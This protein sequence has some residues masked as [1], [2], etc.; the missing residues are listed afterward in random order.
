MKY[1]KYIILFI[2][3][4]PLTVFADDSITISNL[5]LINKEG[6]AV[7]LNPA[8]VT[9]TTI[10]LDTK[11]YEV[12]DSIEYQFTIENNT[13][14]EYGIDTSNINSEYIN[15]Q[16]K[17]D[18]GNII[19]P[20]STNTYT[21]T[22]T[23]QNE[24]PQNSFK[25]GKFEVGLDQLLELKDPSLINPLTG[26]FFY[27]LLLFIVSICVVFILKL[28]Y[29]KTI[30]ILLFISV[31]IIPYYTHATEMIH[32]DFGLKIGNI[33]PTF[34]TY[35]GEI[36]YG[37]EYVNGQFTYYYGK[38][39]M[40][41]NSNQGWRWRDIGDGWNV[42]LTDKESIDP[43]TTTLCTYIN[44][45]PIT[46]LASMFEDSKT[47]SIDTSS[48][49]T[50]HITSMNSMFEVDYYG[51]SALSELDVSNF[52]TSNV[53]DISWMFSC[54]K[55][56]TSID[57]SNFD[58][59][60]VIYLTGMFDCCESLTSIDVS[61]F[62]TSKVID[63]YCMFDCCESLTSIDV[64][65][66]DTSNVVN[67]DYMFSYCHSLKI[68]D[69]SNFD[70]SNVTT[71]YEMFESCYDL[72]TLNI[73]N[74]SFDSLSSYGRLYDMFYD[75][76]SLTTLYIN[77]IDISRFD[78]YSYFEEMTNDLDYVTTLYFDDMD[79]TGFTS[80]DDIYEIFD[81]FLYDCSYLE[82]LYI[83]N[84]KLPDTGFEYGLYYFFSEIYDDIYNIDVSGWDLSN[85][86]S[87]DYMFYNFNDLNTIVGL[88]TWDTSDVTSMYE[89]FYDCDDLTSI[90]LSS[91]DMSNVT[92]IDY[93]FYDCSS[94]TTV[95]ARTQADIDKLSASSYLPSVVQF[96]LKS[97]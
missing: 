74:F 84:W 77:N 5:T 34:C 27:I 18:N 63:M 51:S 97:V 12:G 11:M 66:F 49:N 20:S 28:K 6:F 71:F 39:Y 35:D 33:L 3:L 23:Y 14:N 31:F 69:V 93:M 30:I 22:A 17:S 2:F 40:Y 62:D 32:L 68:L 67:M 19:K 72:E 94:L 96:V 95:Y 47:S 75:C 15:Y 46:S 65:N 4:F 83:R 58:T 91:F 80:S 87:L 81:D 54:C 70:T 52:D 53:T 79:M 8:I 13:N 82:K 42:R 59:S 48:Y 29:K 73:S 37:T 60:G 64:S 89:M 10:S 56:L 85:V 92:Y 57:V 86:T 41:D 78:S 55:D 7:E 26:N 36:E 50:S 38:E 25:G 45:I 1:L 16:L 21:L 44:D 88:D 61:N 9:G 43:V 76:Y 24:V 90:D